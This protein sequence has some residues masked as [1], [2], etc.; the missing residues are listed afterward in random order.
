MFIT[1]QYVGGYYYFILEMVFRVETFIL[2]WRKPKK[3]I[4]KT[5][6]NRTSQKLVIYFLSHLSVVIAVETGQPL[7]LS[8]SATSQGIPRQMDTSSMVCT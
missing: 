4:L 5:L 6:R 1:R 2:M 7:S 8:S 3:N